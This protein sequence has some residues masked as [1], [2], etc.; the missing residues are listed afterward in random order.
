MSDADTVRDA[1]GTKQV[2]KTAC[3]S[4]GETHDAVTCATQPGALPVEGDFVVCER[5]GARLTFTGP[6]PLI[7]RPMSE[8]ERRALF[9]QDPQALEAL[10]RMHREISSR[11]RLHPTLA[12]ALATFEALRRLRFSSD[13]I[14]VHY[15]EQAQQVAVLL[16]TFEGKQMAIEAGP[17]TG[18]A[19]AFAAAWQQAAALWNGDG[20]T[21]AERGAVC[22]GSRIRARGPEVGAALR[23]KGIKI[24]GAEASAQQRL[25]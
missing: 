10:D 17:Y 25:S 23:A 22:A 18:P 11:S 1:L 19:D 9:R 20:M 5:C 4:C 24:P 8:D 15:D 16:R 13:E 21:D 14:F 12:E 2:P 7:L 3:P 6:L